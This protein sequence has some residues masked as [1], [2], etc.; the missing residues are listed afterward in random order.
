MIENEPCIRCQS[1]NVVPGYG[2]ERFVVDSSVAPKR[3]SWFKA[4]HD[5]QLKEIA[6]LCLDCG[7]VWTQA[8][9][10]SLEQLRSVLREKC[11]S[12]QRKPLFDA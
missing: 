8:V 9:P 4:V 1:A 10:E 7:T 2:F 11:D 12:E 5:V 3:P 6:W